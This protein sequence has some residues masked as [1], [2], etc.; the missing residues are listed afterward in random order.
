MKLLEYIFPT[1]LECSERCFDRAMR[2]LERMK[3][4]VE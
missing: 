4:I 2:A 3:E 1:P